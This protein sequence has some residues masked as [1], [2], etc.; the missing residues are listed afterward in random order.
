[1]N[2]YMEL[3]QA[4]KINQ[5]LYKDFGH[6]VIGLQKVYDT[7]I[8]IQDF[9]DSVY[10]KPFLSYLELLNKEV[11]FNENAH[12]FRRFLSSCEDRGV[13]VFVFSNANENWC[14]T[15]LNTMKVENFSS[16]HIIGCDSDAYA[17][18]KELGLKPHKA[19]YTKAVQYIY[20]QLQDKDEKEFV[21]VDDQLQNLLPVL[22]NNYWKPVWFNTDL[23][24]PTLCTP[25][26]YTVRDISGLYSYM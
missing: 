16:K 24:K 6:T 15:V 3:E 2:P 26:I 17:S 10:D 25:S 13:P 4:E 21:Y 20:K 7:N 19:A 14:R 5:V 23:E 12:E 11:S 18:S 9:C 8:S 22:H 1:V